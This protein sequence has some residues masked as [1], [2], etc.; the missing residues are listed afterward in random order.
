MRR[1]MAPLR[2]YGFSYYLRRSAFARL[3]R[4]AALAQHESTCPRRR[5]TSACCVND[6]LFNLAHDPVRDLGESTALPRLDA[7]ACAALNRLHDKRAAA[8]AFAWRGEVHRVQWAFDE[9]AMP[10]HDVYRFKLGGHS[11]RLGLD[12]P[13][14]M[15][16]FDEPR[17][18]QLPRDLRAILLADAAHELVDALMRATRLTFE[19]LPGDEPA[20]PASPAAQQAACFRVVTSGAD[21][22]GGWRGFVQ[23]DD[24]AALA[25]LAPPL[26]PRAAP[27]ATA[28]DPL[29][30]L[31][32]P[33]RWRIGTTQIR[34]REVRSVR[35]GDIVSVEDWQSAGAAIVA[36]AEAGAHR[37]VALA[38]GSRITIQQSRDSTM[39]RNRD[40]A[41]NATEP[42][43]AVANAPIDRLD[44]LE[45]TLRFEVGDLE[46]S[47]GELR[48]LRAGHV[49]E[50][51][52][53]LNRSV[54]RILAHGNL[55]GKGYL[56]A[57]GERLG[58]RVSE[59]APSEI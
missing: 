7:R 23:F 57:V 31:R 54:V 21:P 6:R 14:Q 47:L 28:V 29:A 22:S 37:F 26:G 40:T 32:F 45:V 18:E 42:Q 36:T 17:L 43:E 56:V 4:I 59:F 48:N 2:D 27:P 35:A 5:D 55:L 51:G 33:L 30:R 25:D 8:L 39:N 49:F 46:V 44:A 41:T 11:G 34:L 12:R 9:S 10:P 13:A 24:A 3:Q 19:W 20:A 16:L 58:V 1:T 15:R 50:L 52:Q 53:P 38:E